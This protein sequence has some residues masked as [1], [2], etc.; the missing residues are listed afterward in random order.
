MVGLPYSDDLVESVQQYRRSGRSLESLDR[1][2]YD[3]C[4]DSGFEVRTICIK[5]KF[6]FP[7]YVQPICHPLFLSFNGNVTEKTTIVNVN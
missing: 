4:W 6:F 7:S 2:I 5:V 3:F 1:T